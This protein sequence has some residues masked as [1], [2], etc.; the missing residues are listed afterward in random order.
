MSGDII[1][2]CERKVVDYS[3]SNRITKRTCGRDGIGL[4][5][6]RQK[7]TIILCEMHS[8]ECD[9]GREI[10]QFQRRQVRS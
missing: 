6:T 5:T 7:P 2:N 3:E 1:G 9:T 8:S 4:F 10:P